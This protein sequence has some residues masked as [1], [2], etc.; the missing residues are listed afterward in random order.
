M[1]IHRQKA[2]LF[3]YSNFMKARI[4]RESW[5]E[6]KTSN[7]STHICSFNQACL[8][9]K[10]TAVSVCS[11][12]CKTSCDNKHTSQLSISQHFINSDSFFSRL[13]RPDEN[14]DVSLSVPQY[15]G[16][17]PPSHIRYHNLN[18][19]VRTATRDVCNNLSRFRVQLK[20]N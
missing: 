16:H 13:Q 10:S 2:P 6:V 18:D 7:N 8:F 14:L 19:Q 17:P 11:C 9:I 12:R 20:S 5:S 1:N 4:R 3:I 15:N